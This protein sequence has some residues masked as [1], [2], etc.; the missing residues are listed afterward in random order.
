MSAKLA[1]LGVL[2][3]LAAVVWV[4][5]VATLMLAAVPAAR[6][7]LR[8][9]PKEVGAY[10]A[11]VMKRFGPLSSLALLVLLVTGPMKLG[12]PGWRQVSAFQSTWAGI[13]AVKLVLVALVV[14]NTLYLSVVL[15]V[16]A[17]RLSKE[18]GKEAE[19]ALVR[20]RQTKLGYVN[21]V[22]GLLI[23]V[24]MGVAG[25]LPG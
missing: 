16:R 5:G 18:S 1:I 2:H 12:S 8:G 20:A 14:L 19:L 17:V 21:L 23:V 7:R 10:T 6:E 24:L 22:L 9:D 25:S 13:M 3:L 15:T 4:G 11:A